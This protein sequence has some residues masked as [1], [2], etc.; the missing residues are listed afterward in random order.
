MAFCS[1]CGQII[2][3]GARFCSRCGT[4]IDTNSNRKQVFEG[5]IHKCP[6]CGEKI[7]SFRT[8]CPSCGYE[9]RDSQT[10]SAVKKFE[11]QIQE[12]ESQRNSNPSDSVK[13]F[14]AR[15]DAINEQK[16][17]LIRSFSV[18]NTKEDMIEFLILASSNIDDSLCES[19][20][21]STKKDVSDAWLAK[22]NQVYNK[23]KIAFGTEP[24]F[25]I[26]HN[27]YDT[28]MKAIKKK[29]QNQNILLT[30]TV[31]FLIFALGLLLIPQCQ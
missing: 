16:I 15:S 20:V 19:G 1:S 12:I 4:P 7:S 10:S 22:T 9:F 28:K 24:D 23:A 13:S 14:R 17:N 5:N 25:A 6:N 11:R 29:E 26:V 27:I 21:D 2:E 31:L 3:D 30:G 18:P 8:N